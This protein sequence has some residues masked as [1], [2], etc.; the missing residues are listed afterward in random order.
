MATDKRRIL[1]SRWRDMIRR[2]YNKNRRDYSRYGGKG[3]TVCER[4]DSFDNFLQDMEDGF[5]DN[6]T[7]ERIDYEKGYSP[8][9][10]RWAT[11]TEQN[12]NKINNRNITIDGVTKTLS[13]WIEKSSV[14]SSTVRQRFYVYGWTVEK[15]L[16]F[17][18][19]NHNG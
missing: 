5:S 4:W 11:Y 6:L 2:C 13:E 9:N 1:L 3:I 17:G 12:R 8:E 16:G 14:K 7:L 15:A 19:G 18:G 10:C